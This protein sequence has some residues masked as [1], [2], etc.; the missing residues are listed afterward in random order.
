MRIGPTTVLE[1]ANPRSDE[2]FQRLLLRFSAAAARTTSPPDLIHLFCRATR[3][4]FQVAGVYF[5]RCAGSDEL[6]GAEADGLMAEHFRGTRLRA[7]GSA[8]AMDAV[9]KRK[10]LY[11]NRVDPVRFPMAGEYHAAAILAA[12]L[13]VSHEVIGAAV[14]LHD[15]NPEFFNDDLAAKATILAGQLGSLLEASRLSLAS[16]EVHRRAEILAEVAQALH[17]V[18]DAAAVIEA[19]ADRLRV[20]LGTRLV[21]VLLREGGTFSLRAV[22]AE[23]P[24]LASW[25]RARHDRKGLY[26]AA[27]LA[28]RAVTA[29]EPV[30]VSIEPTSHSLGDLVPAGA[31]IAAPFRT[32]RC[33]GAVLVYP[34]QA[35]AF[36][37]EEKSLVAAVAGFGAVAIANAELYGTARAQAHELHQLL[38]ISSELGSIS[39]LDRFLQQFSIRAADFLGF[40]R[41]FIGL[42]EEDG[43]FHVRWGSDNGKNVLVDLRFPDGIASRALLNKEV[44]SADDAA[45]LPDANLEVISEFQVR[46]LLAVP[47]LGTEGQVLGMFGV[48]NRFDQA[49]ISKEDVRRAR[50]LAAQVAVA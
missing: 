1:D 41:A 21:C 37:A 38:E 47:L 24:Q 12:P 45:K 19:V 49:G 9:R 33:Q 30:T 34:R 3:E 23:S 10:T 31:L 4:F 14:F 48:L 28:N 50:V 11:F 17:A 32:S 20:L 8:V 13:V 6:V 5:W 42:L 7:D 2:A 46:Q 18:P 25:V 27:D 29:G 22:A 40:A 35:G 39:D 44:F 43:A 36:T 16:R 15:S 26:F